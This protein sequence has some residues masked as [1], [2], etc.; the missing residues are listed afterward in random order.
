MY[1]E[2]ACL[3]RSKVTLV[4][5]VRRVHLGDGIGWMGWDLLYVVF[6]QESGNIVP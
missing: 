2:V 3:D 6:Q 1:F 4:A 5:F